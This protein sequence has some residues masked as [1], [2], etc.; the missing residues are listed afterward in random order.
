[1]TVSR[2][3]AFLSLDRAWLNTRCPASPQARARLEVVA[4]GAAVKAVTDATLAALTVVITAGV[5]AG[6]AAP[7][8]ALVAP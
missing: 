2:H 6:A 7:S 8:S 3:E 4:G 5:A 1:M